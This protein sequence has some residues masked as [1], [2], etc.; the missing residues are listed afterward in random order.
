VISVESVQEQPVMFENP[1][2]AYDEAP[3]KEVEVT[4]EDADTAI[5]QEDDRGSEYN[6]EEYLDAT[7]KHSLFFNHYSY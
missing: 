4:N 6:I 7:S 1:P 3:K 2:K 5:I